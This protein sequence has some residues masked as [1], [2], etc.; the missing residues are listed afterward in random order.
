MVSRRRRRVAHLDESE[1]LKKQR[2]IGRKTT[3]HARAP[4]GLVGVLPVEGA[5]VIGQ[6]ARPPPGEARR[7]L[8]EGS[9]GREEEQREQRGD[10]CAPHRRRQGSR[11]RRRCR[12]SQQYSLR[13]PAVCAARTC[14]T[15]HRGGLK[16]SRSSFGNQ[17]ATKVAPARGGELIG[18]KT[19][20]SMSVAKKKKKNEGTPFSLAVDA[21][22][23]RPL[24]SV[25]LE[26]R[27]LLFP[28]NPSPHK[29]VI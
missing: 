7:G 29:S 8:G 13:G 1:K 6:N 19:E 5:A 23:G 2:A 17:R 11:R 21:R 14:S 10:A 18:G 3:H 24:P 25:S 28:S 22:C 16:R 9:R 4:R 27:D 26:A 20:S 15:R 12:T